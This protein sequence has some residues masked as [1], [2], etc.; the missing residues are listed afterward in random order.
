MTDP[1]LP[2]HLDRSILIHAPR[3]TVFSFLTDSDRW[4]KWWGAGSTID[5]EVGG[6]VYIRHPGGI[7]A[8]GKILEIAVPERVV[9]SYGFKT[10]QPMPL[11]A[12]KV[13][14]SFDDEAG[15]TRV[16]VHHE[17]AESTVRDEHVQGWRYQLSLFAN[18]VAGIV[19]AGAA[20]KVDTW[21]GAWAETNAAVRETMLVSV[22][23][24]SVQFRDQFSC[25]DGLTELMPHITA[26]Q[27]FMPGL[28]L[29]REGDVR[30][31]QGT[32]L[33]NWKATGPDGA[34]RGQGTNVFHMAPD[35]RIQSAT[36]LWG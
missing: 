25:V 13:T 33:A 34:P 6:T 23:L 5:P 14:M 26:A 4:A 32:V 21:F 17:F 31:C 19:H 10:G 8:G 35:G 28:K 1:S 22:A 16:R 3:A 18:V 29:A 9:F 2:H 27:K 15:S 20:E 12:S 11:E 24:P 36:G 30:H 7:E